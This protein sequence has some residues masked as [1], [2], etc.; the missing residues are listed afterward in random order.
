VGAGPTAQEQVQQAWR[1]FDAGDLA[2]AIAQAGQAAAAD[3]PSPRACAALGFFLIQ[4]GRLD[5]AAAVVLPAR[6]RDPGYAPLHWYAGY[7]FQQRGDPA[8]AVAAFRRA[9]ELDSMLDEVAFSLAWAL[10]D[11][12]RTEE[13]IG[14]AEH[15]LARARTP[16]RLMQVGW[17]R[18][19]LGEFARAEPA[20]REAI[21]ALDASAPEQPRLQLHLSQCLAHLARE[22]EADE[23]LRQALARWPA[24]AELLGASAW[25]LRARGDAQGALRLA[26]GLVH[27]HPALASVWHLLGVLQQELGELEAAD[28]AFAECQQLDLRMTDA[29]VRRAQIQRQWRQYEGAQWLLGQVL[30]QSPGHEA[31]HGLLAQVLLD[32]GEVDAARRHLHQALRARTRSADLWRL[33]A[34]TQARSG[35]LRSAQR[36]LQRVLARAPDNVEAWRLQGWLALELGDLERAVEAVTRLLALVPADSAAQVQAAFVLLH[37]GRMAQAEAWAE[38]AVA[39]APDLADAWR[40]LSQVR[41]HQ[42]RLG[43]AEAAVQQALRLAPGQHDA[44]RQLGRVWMSAARP[45][46][47]QLAFLRAIEARPDDAAARLELAEARC[48]AGRFEAGLEGLEAVP[49]TPAAR[50][51]TLL[52]KARLLTEGGF[53][54]AA[55]ACAQLLRN[56]RYSAEAVRAI[57]RLVGLG[58]AAARRLLPLV[59]ADLLRSAWRD[60]IVHAFH[61]QSQACLTRLTQAAGEDLDDDPWIAAAA[62]YAASLAS[63]ADPAALARRARD[64]YRG[65]KIRSG[66]ARLPVPAQPVVADRRPRIAYVAGQ[67]HQS[68]LRRVLAAHASERAQVFVYTNHPLAGLPVHVHVRPLETAT[69]AESCAANRIDVV[70]DAGGLHPF[71]G[72][73]EVLEAC[74]RRLAPVQLGWLGCWGSAGGLFDALLTDAAAVPPEHEPCYDERILRLEGGQWCWEPPPAAPDVRPPPVLARGSLSYGVTARSLRLGEACLDAFARVVAATPGSEIRFAGEIAGDWPLRRQ[75]L[76]RMLAHGVAPGRVFFDPFVPYAAYLEWLGRIDLVLDS[77]PG[78]GGFSLLDPLW[79]GVPVVTLAGAW[80]GTRQGASLLAALRLSQ[81]VAQSEDG[82][83]ATATALARDTAALSQHRFTLRD[84][85]LGSPLVDG[86]RV[87]AQIEDLCARLKQGATSVAAAP[88]AKSRTRVHAQW[89]LDAWL[90][91]PRGIELPAV[92]AEATPELSVIVVLY[93]QAGLSLRTLQALADQRGVRFE[94]IV[95]DNASSDRTAELLGR[96]RG[97]RVIRNADNAGFLRGIRQGAAA[98]R[99]RYLAFLNSDAILHEGALSATLRAMRAD[100]SIGVLGGRIVL[101][102]GGLQEAGSRIFSDGSAGGIGRGEDAFGHAARAARGADYV[103]AVWFVT[104]ASLWRMLGGFDEAFAPAYYEDTDYCVRVWQAGFRVVY[105]PAVLLEHL[106]FGS[107]TGNS[108]IE[109]M[110]RN[111]D[112]FRARHAAW[113]QGQPSPQALP[114]D[115]DRWGSPEDRPRLPRVLFLD[116][117]VP[118]MVRGGGLPRARLMLQALRD[119]PLTLLPLW[120]P[121]DDWRAVYATLPGSVE[122]ALGYG[123]AGLEAFLERRRGVYDVLLVSRPSNLQ[124]LQPLR[125]RRPELFAGMRLVYDAEALF[126]LREIAMAGVQGRPLARDAARARVDAEVALAQGAS[127]VLV[128]SERDARYFE[129]AG[130]RTHVVSHG[131]AP[132]RSAPGPAGRTGL[133]F[134]GALHPGTPNEDGLLWF[135]REVMPRLRQHLPVAPVLSVVGVCG[136][137]RVAALAGPDVRLLGPQEALEPHYDA[138]RVFVAPVRFAGGVPAKVIEAAAHGIPVVASALLVRQL[139]WRDGLDILGARDAV[140]FAAAIARLLLD[141]ASWQRQQ[142]AAWEQCA[143]RYDPGMFGETLRR[144]LK[145]EPA[146]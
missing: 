108:A 26:R 141:D 131:I 53:D 145:A 84:R 126:A 1:L 4:S 87:A 80:L 72:Q 134:V 95:V 127:D 93:N 18:Q 13:A 43:E 67:L 39:R 92:A 37:A 130:H 15:A 94:T 56:D 91:Q 35:R 12:G 61:T 75:V 111:R 129:A 142:H 122:V 49:D 73:F 58:S 100:A 123:L 3:P 78:N 48:R 89:A 135:L 109:L 68:L 88:D 103:S 136:S 146:A 118:H 30:Q 7:L 40:A 17:L 82:F 86:R 79:M 36:T 41:L 74:A 20:Y 112:L 9:F 101:A 59:P 33:L 11:L 102:D 71:E 16:Q 98:A 133:L 96:L 63:H 14:W 25:R 70:I 24:D 90:A 104:P 85:I 107:A 137:D 2:G 105:E 21:Q 69:L 124:A 5:E 144:V 76:A 138:A 65:L 119:W 116:N 64:W 143:V 45:G 10:H 77:F 46:H 47:A 34:V 44:L 99:G 52:M 140:A 121:Q 55:D 97:A 106:E 27:R 54:G 83:C 128:V 139:R 120:T 115:G 57:L 8:G 60:A 66:S 114:L 28:A 31:A 51:P 42:Q 110:E 125:T 29:L 50:H 62:L 38:R 22:H 117:E 19:K 6:E 113:L 81:W 32:L 23:V 132:R